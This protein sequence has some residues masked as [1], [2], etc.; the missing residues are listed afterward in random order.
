MLV[1]EHMRQLVKACRPTDREEALEL[2]A[3]IKPIK[4]GNN[5]PWSAAGEYNL[6]L[7]QIPPNV[8]N[9][10]LRV[11]FYTTNTTAGAADYGQYQPPPT[12][13]AWWR[14]LSLAPGFTYDLT[15]MNAPVQL[16]LDADEFLIFQGGYNV[17]LIGDLAAS[18]DADDR[19]LRCLIYSYNCGPAVV[20][21]IGRGEA[22][23]KPNV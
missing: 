2:W 1:L 4:F 17:S 14:Y 20:D 19:E 7:Y 13:T 16:A 23:I 6:A 22:I 15:D 18:P 9:I 11:E 12:G 5:L 21:R 3:D 8:Y 10:P